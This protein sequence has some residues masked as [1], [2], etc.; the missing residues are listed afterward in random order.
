MIVRHVVNAMV[1]YDILK[2]SLPKIKGDDHMAKE[3]KEG[4]N[5]SRR[6]MYLAGLFEL[7][8]S[9]FLFTSVFGKLGRKL[10]TLGTIMINIVMGAAIFHHF[11]AGH[12]FKGAKAAS[13]Y[14][15]MNVLSLIEVLALNRKH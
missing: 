1:G 11:K 13:K 6:S 7:V 8:G 10:V 5:L 14:F 4:F 3:F 12:G 2:S 9:I 15:V